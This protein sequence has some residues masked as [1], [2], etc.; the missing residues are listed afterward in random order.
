MDYWMSADCALTKPFLCETE[1]TSGEV[2]TAFPPTLPTP[3]TCDTANPNDGWIVDRGD[4]ERQFCYYFGTNTVELQ[5]TGV[6]NSNIPAFLLLTEQCR[7]IGVR[8]YYIY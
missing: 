6:Q 4:P 1:E 5:F 3:A 2:T 8:L 7:Y